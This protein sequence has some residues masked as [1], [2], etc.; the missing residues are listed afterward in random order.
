MNSN[1]QGIQTLAETCPAFMPRD[2]SVSARVC[3]HV[4]VNMCVREICHV[5]IVL[6]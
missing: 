5:K 3:V 2:I 4:C 1:N 6:F